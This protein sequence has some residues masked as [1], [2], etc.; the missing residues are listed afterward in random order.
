MSKM[1]KSKKRHCNR[2]TKKHRKYRKNMR[3]GKYTDAQVEQLL[4]AG[5]TPQFLKIAYKGKVGF[6][7]LFNDLMGY[8]NS[9]RTAQ[10]YMRATYD[11]LDI[12]PND[13]MTSEE[14]EDSDQAGGKKTRKNRK[15]MRGGTL[16]GRGYGAN[17]Y[18]PNYSIYN[19][20]LLKL[21]PYSA[22]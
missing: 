20:N 12:D 9:G 19:T 6:N 1:S 5:I 14:D 7:I 4:N 10:D 21:F 13:G 18:D 22:K 8:I 15:Y 17:C 16:Y 2:K 3:G 11:D